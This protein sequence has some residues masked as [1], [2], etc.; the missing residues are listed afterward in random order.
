MT[1]EQMMESRGFKSESGGYV[2]DNG[3]HMNGLEY[4][5]VVNADDTGKPLD[6]TSPCQVIVSNDVFDEKHR[7]EYASVWELV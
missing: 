6:M 2:R 1:V 7:R 5:F 4:T 3:C